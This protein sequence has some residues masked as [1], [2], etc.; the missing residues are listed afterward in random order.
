MAGFNPVN[1]IAG[2]AIITWNSYTYYSRGDIRVAFRRETW[3][4]ATSMHGRVDSR[5]RSLSAEVSFQPVGMLDT[6]AKYW[7]YV[8]GDIGKSIFAASDKPLII[9]T[10]EG[11]KY[12]LPRAA[13]SRMPSLKLTA[14]D[15]L[16]QGDLTFL[17][18]LKTS[19]EITTADSIL[20]VEANAFSD[21]SFD[22]T[23]ID[24]AGYTAALGARSSPYTAM[25]SLDGFTI[26][27]GMTL[28]EDRV[29]RYGLV[30]ARLTSLAAAAR[31][32]PVGLTEAEWDALVIPDGASALVPG[33]SVAAA[34]ENLVIS[35]T[36]LSVTLAKAGIVNHALAFGEAPRL[37]EIQFAC[38]RSWTAGVADALWTITIS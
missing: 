15:T 5:L 17:C 8:A 33:Q 2:P 6:A 36:G 3:D 23:K 32:T 35:G 12:T 10:L 11:R 27:F 38:Q 13:I 20:K 25:E 16:I 4:V 26:D 29:D 9:Q 14:A 22:E 28:R 21:T 19:T 30:A 31:F 18:L 24:S 37:G 1:F 34:A 7:P